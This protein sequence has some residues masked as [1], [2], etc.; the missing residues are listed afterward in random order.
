MKS[1]LLGAIGCCLTWNGVGQAQV[2]EFCPVPRNLVLDPS[3]EIPC[4]GV[5]VSK[6]RDG[7]LIARPRNSSEDASELMVFVVHDMDRLMLSMMNQQTEY[8]LYT[9]LKR[10]KSNGN[11]PLIMELAHNGHRR[12][13]TVRYLPRERVNGEH[14]EK[15]E[16]FCQILDL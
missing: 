14:R 7:R 13:I 1:Y 5:I 9:N 3:I 15:I 16:G 8:R 11:Y 2:C 4:Q 10:G 6:M 12:Q